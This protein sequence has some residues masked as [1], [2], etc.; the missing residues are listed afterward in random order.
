MSAQEAYRVK[1]VNRLVPKAELLETAQ[2]VAKKIA[3]HDPLA[4]RYAKEAV[5]RGLDLTLSEGLALEKV[6]GSRLRD[7]VAG[8]VKTGG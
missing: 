1:L 8:E 5:L 2:R 6:L 7:R 4:V 3:S